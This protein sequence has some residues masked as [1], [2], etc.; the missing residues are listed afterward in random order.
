MRSGKLGRPEFSHKSL[1]VILIPKEVADV[2]AVEKSVYHDV[3]EYGYSCNPCSILSELRFDDIFLGSAT[4]AAI[5]SCC[6]SRNGVV[7]VL[8]LPSAIHILHA[9]V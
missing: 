4:S 2:H 3:D 9:G 8:S 6:K 1:V 7:G 5:F